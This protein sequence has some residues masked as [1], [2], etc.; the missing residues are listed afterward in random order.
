MFDIGS[1]FQ[2]ENPHNSGLYVQLPENRR[3][4]Y[5]FTVVF[6]LVGA[7][8]FYK[9]Y[10]AL[11]LMVLVLAFIFMVVSYVKADLLLPLNKL[12]LHFGLL[13]SKISSPIIF[14]ALFFCLFSPIA[15]FMRFLGRDELSLIFKERSSFWKH[16]EEDNSYPQ[17]FKN[18]F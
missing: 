2:V 13:L 8:L 11:A 12:W 6:V 1:Q 15:F 3:F 9:G 18:Q 7:Y 16:R 5:F 10:M 4:G 14:G 17:T